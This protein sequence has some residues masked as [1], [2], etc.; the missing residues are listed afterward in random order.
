MEFISYLFEA[1]LFVYLI[2][3]KDSLIPRKQKKHQEAA[4][5]LR[6]S[7]LAMEGLQDDLRIKKF[8]TI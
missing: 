2:A 8:L 1:I 5:M 7:L 3:Y 4:P 6:S